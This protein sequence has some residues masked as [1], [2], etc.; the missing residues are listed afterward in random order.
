MGVRTRA[1]ALGLAV[2]LALLAPPAH[3]MRLEVRRDAG[4]PR[5]VWIASPDTTAPLS[6]EAELAF[7]RARL[8]DT[9]RAATALHV[10]ADLRAA[11]GDSVGADSCLFS[12][13]GRP[14]PW[15]WPA[16]QRLARHVLVRLGAAVADSV[17]AAAADD[18]PVGRVDWAPAE[19]AAWLDARAELRLVA[20]DTTHSLAFSRQVLLKYPG[21]PAPAAAAFARIDSITRARSDSLSLTDLRDGST[22]AYLRGARPLAIEL[23]RRA[24]AR[25][26]SAGRFSAALGLASLLRDCRY[27]L[28]A[29]GAATTARHL[30]RN[31]DQV[32]RADLERARD[33]RDAARTDSALALYAQ[34]GKAAIDSDRRALAW[35]E[36]GRECEDRCRYRDALARF[37]RVLRMRLEGDGSLN[38]EIEAGLMYV[39]LGRPD[40]AAALFLSDRTRLPERKLFWLAL[41]LRGRDRERS[42]S[43]LAVLA[44]A[45]GYGIYRSAARE[46]LGVRGWPDSIGATNPSPLATED[47]VRALVRC[48]RSD[49]AA[50]WIDR[51]SLTEQPADEGADTASGE[52]QQEAAGPVGLALGALAY[53]AGRP[54]L[55]LR[56]S[57]S[58]TSL[59]WSFVPWAYPPAYANEVQAE[60]SLVE[61]ALMMALIRQESRFDPSAR[62][63][64]DALG[65]T[66]LKLATAADMARALHEPAPVDTTLFD[67]AHAV[68]YGARYLAQLMARFGGDPAVALAAYNAGASHVRPDWRELIARGGE[69][70]YCELASNADSQ[71]YVKRI[72]G[73][74]QA[75]RELRP[76][77]AP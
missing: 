75:Y 41:A 71:D 38:T 54:A 47:D 5:V 13:A 45:S 23:A 20:G 35:W 51:A 67:P 6:G 8:A 53:D 10:L 44:C 40:S 55:A 3:A 58:S 25:A 64:S 24:L 57:N 65:L 16:L 48:G 27:P 36:A 46:T 34:V 69:A 32:A 66:Q 12:L 76:V 72:L 50:R 22:A 9:T 11:A 77:A 73:F 7:W 59:A 56:L 17:M 43:L 37:Q 42:D 52:R 31:P 49:D 26:D 28:T 74:R 1:A 4:G 15:Q 68:R 2:A 30:A 70:L 61:P 18:R 19:R 39:A 62:S 21:V 29:S 14:G 33:L 60:S 63:K